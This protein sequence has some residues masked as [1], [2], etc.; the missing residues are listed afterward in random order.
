MTLYYKNGIGI[1]DDKWLSKCSMCLN[2]K[3]NSE[4]FF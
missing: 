1:N 4:M 3:A 2:G